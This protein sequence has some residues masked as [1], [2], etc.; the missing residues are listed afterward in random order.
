MSEKNAK[1][2]ENGIQCTSTIEF[3][4]NDYKQAVKITLP[5]NKSEIIFYS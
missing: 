4:P 2:T 5:S 1:F 3:L